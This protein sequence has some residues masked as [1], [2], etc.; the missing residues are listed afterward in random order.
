MIMK[1]SYGPDKISSSMFMFLMNVAGSIPT[2]FSSLFIYER[3]GTQMF[4]MFY[5]SSP[6]LFMHR[7]AMMV[8]LSSIL[9]LKLPYIYVYFWIPKAHVSASAGLS[10]VLARIIL[11]L[12]TSGIYKYF[13]I[14]KGTLNTLQGLLS[15][16]LMLFCTI[17]LFM[18]RI[19]DQKYLVAL[20]SILHMS[21]IPFLFLQGNQVSAHG[22]ILGISRHGLASGALFIIVGYLYEKCTNRSRQR[23]KGI[24]R[25]SRSYCFLIV[26]LIIVNIG[27]PPFSNFFREIRMLGSFLSQSYFVRGLFCLFI[28]VSII[29]T[30]RFIINY[31]S[32]KSTS[33]VFMSF[34]ARVGVN[35]MMLSFFLLVLSLLL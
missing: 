19:F 33:P 5:Y 31:R 27:L 24:E 2:L 26:V 8:L 9:L 35:S 13:H 29:L 14:F 34:N 12:A 1:R 30:M 18:I 6:S 7:G 17:I 11:K 3:S 22:A 32:R 21:F 23:T 10:V 20:S 28:V 4:S 15:L 16:S 25:I